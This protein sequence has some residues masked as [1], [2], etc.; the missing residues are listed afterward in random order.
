MASPEMKKEKEDDGLTGEE[1][2]R[3]ELWCTGRKRKTERGE[4][5]LLS[6]VE[7]KKRGVLPLVLPEKYDSGNAMLAGGKETKG[8]REDNLW[9]I[10]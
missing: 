5:W 9:Q 1:E 4:E 3:G 2:N 8:K 10:W 6:P 7:I